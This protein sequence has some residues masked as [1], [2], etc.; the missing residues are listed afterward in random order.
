MNEFVGRVEKTLSS[1]LV[2]DKL[3]KL[4]KKVDILRAKR[5]K[6][7]DSFLSGLVLEDM[8]KEKDENF[9]NE[10][11]EIEQQIEE[12][13]L[14][15]ENDAVINRR[16]VELRKTLSTNMVLTKFDR[17]VFESIV[18]KVIVGGYDKDDNVK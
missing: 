1:K 3:I 4:Y 5:Q 17:E 12:N 18:E 8:Y 9:K 13:E 2:K 11:R 6:L 7:L 14:L 16:I 10:L 15:R